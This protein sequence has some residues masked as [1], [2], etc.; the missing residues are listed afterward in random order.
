MVRKGKEVTWTAEARN[1]S[2][3]IKKALT[4]AHV[5]IS[6]YYSKDFL[7]FSFASFDIVA[8]VLLQHNT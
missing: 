5:L 1:S 7:I 4:E 2:D 8:F 3:Q 6:L